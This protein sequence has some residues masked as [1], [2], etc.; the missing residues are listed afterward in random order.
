MIR[1]SKSIFFWL[2]DGLPNGTQSLA[3]GTWALA[4]SSPSSTTTGRRR[5][6]GSRSMTSSPSRREPDHER[7]V[8]RSSQELLTRCR[9]ERRWVRRLVS[10]GERQRHGTFTAES[11]QWRI[12]GCEVGAGSVGG[13]AGR[14]SPVGFLAARPPIALGSGAKTDRSGSRRPQNASKVT[15]Q[16]SPSRRRWLQNARLD[17]PALFFLRWL[18][19]DHPALVAGHQLAAEPA[20]VE[21]REHDD[22][23]QREAPRQHRVRRSLHLTQHEVH[24]REHH[25]KHVAVQMIPGVGDGADRLLGEEV[26]EPGERGKRA[27]DEG[28]GDQPQRGRGPE[29]RARAPECEIAGERAHQERDGEGNQHRMNRMAADARARSSRSHERILPGQYRPTL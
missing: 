6:S 3:L 22:Q 19:L 18:F 17:R 16:A 1:I 28:G 14:N 24:E 2:W 26:V 27:H 8:S 29:R 7:N 10:T 4:P 11:I 12:F 9:L 21:E 23:R 13:K 20:G 15:I 5:A 25:G